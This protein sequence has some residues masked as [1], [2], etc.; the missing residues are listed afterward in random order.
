MYC[1]STRCGASASATLSCR[2]VAAGM[3]C[4]G[5]DRHSPSALVGPV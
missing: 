2:A 1:R 3:R 4:R 5:T